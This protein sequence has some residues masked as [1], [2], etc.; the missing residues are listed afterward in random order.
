MTVG[1]SLLPQW[2]V[3]HP[4]TDGQRIL[5]VLGDGCADDGMSPSIRVILF[6]HL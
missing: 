3:G 6:I 4:G 2:Y 1:V 5:Q